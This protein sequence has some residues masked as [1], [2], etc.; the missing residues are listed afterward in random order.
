MQGDRVRL[1][2]PHNKILNGH[3]VQT[4][5]EGV[6]LADPQ[7]EIEWVPISGGRMARSIAYHDMSTGAITDIPDIRFEDVGGFESLK[8]ALREALIWPIVH[9]DLF[10]ASSIKP[11]KGVLLTGEPGSGKTLM[12]QALAYE[13]QINVISLRG[14][15][16]FHPSKGDGESTLREAFTKA[17]QVAPSL[18]LIDE[19]DVL[20]QRRS[21]NRPIE[22]ERLSALLLAEIDDLA[23]AKG[24]F[25]LATTHCV[26]EIDPALLRPGRF[27]VMLAIPKPDPVMR[28]DILALHT[29]A[30]R[31]AKDVNLNALARATEG[32]VG[33]ELGALCQVAA[34]SA[35]K[36][37]IDKGGTNS[38]L[39][40]LADDMRHAL[41]TITEGRKIRGLEDT[42][43][44]EAREILP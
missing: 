14:S 9:A 24:V 5:P 32:F 31:L 37:R 19:I 17:R 38:S 44:A 11:P 22:A 43:Q 33:A 2:L 13:A 12:A 23:A 25:L 41:A 7:T 20:A 30:L 28:E 29:K 8:T 3:V 27:D 1:V 10:E 4:K 39:E 35:L 34:R 36:R 40:I 15:H 16:L 6:V 18:L 42:R 21:Q 26:D